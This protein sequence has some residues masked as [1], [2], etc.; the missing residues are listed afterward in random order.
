[1]SKKNHKNDFLSQFFDHSPNYKAKR[2]SGYFKFLRL[3]KQQQLL[4]IYNQFYMTFIFK[5]YKLVLANIA[6]VLVILFSFSSFGFG[7]IT[8]A[9]S[10]PGAS[11]IPTDSIDTTRLDDCNLDIA[12]AKNFRDTDFGILAIKNISVAE[13]KIP[14]VEPLVS[15]NILNYK[16]DFSSNAIINCYK[17]NDFSYE[18]LIRK[19]FVDYDNYNYKSVDLSYANVDSKGALERFKFKVFQNP[20]TN[21]IQVVT[22]VEPGLK[23]TEFLVFT[24]KEFQF[25]LTIRAFDIEKNSENTIEKTTLDQ[26]VEGL[27][28]NYNEKKDGLYSIKVS[29]DDTGYFSSI[30]YFNDNYNY[31]QEVQTQNY[32][33]M[34]QF[35]GILGVFT[36]IVILVCNYIL[37]KKIKTKIALQ[38]KIRLLLASYGLIYLIFVNTFNAFASQV[39]FLYQ[40]YNYRLDIAAMLVV[41]GLSFVLTVFNWKKLSKRVRLIDL[42][43]LFVYILYVVSLIFSFSPYY[44]GDGTADMLS[45]V[46]LYIFPAFFTLVWV[47]Y[48][49]WNAYLAVHQIWLSSKTESK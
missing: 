7:L 14:S 22:A 44:S 25:L 47:S 37:N 10:N 24:I 33:R 4:Q 48:S 5:P 30:E 15:A 38:T 45:L 2:S 19:Q 3:Q 35:F 41:A 12:F 1:M 21:N 23:K 42:A 9:E 32:K 8:Q 43:F 46:W 26:I 17:W 29:F 39:D 27:N 36:I 16:G 49:A 28:I 11:F 6:I 31:N 40:V 13:S 18:Y 34:L 20:D